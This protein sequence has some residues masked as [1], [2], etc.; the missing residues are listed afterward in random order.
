M[1][2]E[3]VERQ[4]QMRKLGTGD[5]LLPANSVQ[6]TDRYYRIRKWVDGPHAGVE[7]VRTVWA[8]LVGYGYDLDRLSLESSPW[9]MP[10]WR[11][12]GDYPSRTE[13]VVAALE[14]DRTVDQ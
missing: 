9:D 13:A 10:E 6:Q 11:D 5:Y 2:T 8:L 3:T 14:H 1:A 12:L 7:R 4:W